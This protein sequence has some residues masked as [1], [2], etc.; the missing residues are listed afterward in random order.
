M[1]RRHGRVMGQRL[2]ALR[3]QMRAEA[4]RKAP[5]PPEPSRRTRQPTAKAA[6]DREMIV[7]T[8]VANFARLCLA[9]PEDARLA[10]RMAHSKLT[11]YDR[12][13][14]GQ[15]PKVL[16]R[17]TDRGVLVMHPA[18]FRQRLTT[19]G[20]GAA[21]RAACEQQGVTLEDITKAPGEEPILLFLRL[22]K[23]WA[24]SPRPRTS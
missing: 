11:R 1:I 16:K 18:V 9:E 7:A 15:L 5:P 2:A 17:L 20:P 6:K 22:G 23:R 13:G 21:L 14:F 3:Q 24:A 4:A 12:P 8:I 10:V 19:F